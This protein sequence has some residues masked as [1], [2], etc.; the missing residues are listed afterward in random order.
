[1]NTQAIVKA[2]GELVTIDT[3]SR[4][5]SSR[6]TLFRSADRTR[7]FFEDEIDIFDDF[8]Y[9]EFIERWLPNYSSSQRVAESNDL[10]VCIDGEADDEKLANVKDWCGD[11]LEEWV[12]EQTRIDAALFAEAL[13]NFNRQKYLNDRSE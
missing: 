13:E 3:G 5:S 6:G 11:T 1:M 10:Q 7:T 2:T 4:L 12:E 9:W 8:D